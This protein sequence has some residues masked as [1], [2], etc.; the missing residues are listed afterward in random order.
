M[1]KRTSEDLAWKVSRDQDNKQP[2]C[3][4]AAFL[5][6][7][8]LQDS[9]E[10]KVSQVLEQ[11]AHIQELESEKGWL[12]GVQGKGWGGGVQKTGRRGGLGDWSVVAQSEGTSGPCASCSG[13]WFF[14]ELPEW[15]WVF[16]GAE[17]RL[18][19]GAAELGMT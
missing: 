13:I 1:D 7:V 4:S 14:P 11:Q 2:I 3:V 19:V 10:K 15:K 9:L 16:M 6:Q 18:A 12:G 5:T 8:T 17:G